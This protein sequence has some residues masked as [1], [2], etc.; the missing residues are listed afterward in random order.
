MSPNDSAGS[1]MDSPLHVIGQKGESTSPSSSNPQDPFELQ[2]SGIGGVEPAD[3]FSINVRSRQQKQDKWEPQSAS[4]RS[5]GYPA[6]I[7][8]ALLDRT[9]DALVTSSNSSSKASS[10]DGSSSRRTKPSRARVQREIIGATKT[11]LP[12]S[13]LP[14][15]VYLYFSSD[16]EDEDDD[17]DMA[18]VDDDE[19]SSESEEMPKSAPQYMDWATMVSSKY[20]TEDEGEDREVPKPSTTTKFMP[21]ARSGA[22]QS[23][24]QRKS[25]R[26]PE[27]IDLLA[28]ARTIDPEAA[29]L[30]ERQFDADLA[31]RL[32]KE[33][34]AGS[35]AATGDGGSGFTSPAYVNAT[36]IAP[37]SSVAATVASSPFRNRTGS[38]MPNI[39]TK[40]GVEV[41]K[42][43]KRARKSDDSGV[44]VRARKSPKLD[45]GH[46]DGGS[47]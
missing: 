21:L 26:S 35:S 5:K 40:A 3:N 46:D 18:D 10:V 19:D 36:N 32:A 42:V 14:D 15:A 47:G 13:V 17:E 45:Q 24:S 41:P 43:M 23:R 4:K 34:P 16:D 1:S 29:R 22:L 37:G 9:R 30:Q 27:S 38:V 7:R 8:N 28:P 25:T 44:I 12:A 2:A 20:S 33:I 39:S 6:R 31:E 11:D